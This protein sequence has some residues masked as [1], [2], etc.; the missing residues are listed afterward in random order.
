MFLSQRGLRWK[1]LG[2]I[3]VCQVSVLVILNVEFIQYRNEGIRNIHRTSIS[4][5]HFVTVLPTEP[6]T[7]ACRNNSVHQWSGEILKD[8]NIHCG[9]DSIHLLAVEYMISSSSYS[10]VDEKQLTIDSLHEKIIREFENKQQLQGSQTVN[11]D[12][13]PEQKLFFNT[14]RNLSTIP[15]PYLNLKAKGLAFIKAHE[16]GSTTVATLLALNTYLYNLELWSISQ[17]EQRMKARSIDGECFDVVVLDKPSPNLYKNTE[18][19][20]LFTHNEFSCRRQVKEFMLIRDPIVRLW[21]GYQ[22][23]YQ[24]EDN[25]DLKSYLACNTENCL[26]NQPPHHMLARNVND[27]QNLSTNILFLIWDNQEMM[28][29]SLILLSVEARMNICD[30]IYEPCSRN[31]DGSNSECSSAY[32]NNKDIDE[33]ELQILSQHAQKTGETKFYKEALKRFQLMIFNNVALN[34]RLQNYY[35]VR[36]KA[37]EHCSK[38]SPGYKYA[39][40]FLTLDPRLKQTM[41][42]NTKRWRLK[43]EELHN[44]DAKWLCMQ[45]FC[46][47]SNQQVQT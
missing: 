20:S 45:W 17:L 2:F 23:A 13:N 16:V 29:K 1:I 41:D 44:I 14:K 35:R 34:N 10:V 39:E 4:P 15:K 33:T 21:S 19:A 9:L 12:E 11:I 24:R 37:L 38:E 18:M 31:Q 46:Q 8:Y 36:E 40:I 7:T 28:D 6:P 47:E 25:L 42:A 27:A 3:I 30:F 5:F 43:G 22:Q 32:N 26:S